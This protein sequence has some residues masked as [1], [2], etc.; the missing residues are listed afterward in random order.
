[1]CIRDPIPETKTSIVLLRLSNV[2]PTGTLK[3]SPKS[4]QVNSGMWMP[5]WLKI[6]QLQT[7]L[8]ITAAIERKLLSAFD[9]RVN[10]VIAIAEASGSSNAYHGSMLFMSI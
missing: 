3:P 1:M 8:P 4:I 6:K 10:K 9:L 5:D 7:K 2:K